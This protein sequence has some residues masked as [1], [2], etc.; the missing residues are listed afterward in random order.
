MPLVASLL[1]LSLAASAPA[2]GDPPEGFRAL[3]DGRTLDGWWGAGTEDPRAFQALPEAERA[4]RR[5]A[6]LEALRAHWR[7]EDGVLVNDG[8]GPYLTTVEELGDFELRLS[9]RTVPGADSGVYLRGIPQVQIWDTTE[10]GGNWQIGADRGSGG[11]W[12]N[13]EGA[14]GRDP[15][16]HADRPLGEWNDLRVVMVGERVTVHLNDVLVVDHARLE[17]FFDRAA[18]VPRRGPL[19]LQTHGGEVRWRDVFVRELGA[20][21]ANAWLAER[22]DAEFV[23]VFD[24]ASFAG[25]RG[26]TADYEV[27]DGALQC[28]PGRGGTIFTAREYGDF[29]ARFEFQLPPGGNNGLAIRYPGEGDAAYVGAC[30]LQVLD[31]THPKYAGLDPRQ[32]HGSAYGVVAA[33]RGYLRPVG[34]WNFQQVTVAGSRVRVE[35]NGTCI[36][37]AD[38]AEVEEALYPLEK[39]AGRLRTRGHFGFAG[40]SDP[41]RF[42]R[43][44]VRDDG[45]GPGG[46]R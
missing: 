18:P 46:A 38:L 26:P 12:N 7:V 9:Y 21:E 24:G 16:A 4:A 11:L 10:A 36:L 35:L 6:S 30:E 3:F 8:A 37:D 17:N 33:H 25:W 14:P 39:F 34:E 32:H 31:S 29:A 28:R 42:R 41:V 27:V 44:R 1:C 43:V 2:P 19:Q 45:P 22:G 23:P 13:T 20:D 40:H 5:A 15:L